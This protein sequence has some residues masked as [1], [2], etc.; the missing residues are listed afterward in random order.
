MI[1]RIF[2]QRLEA[3]RRKQKAVGLNIVFHLQLVLKI[4]IC[5]NAR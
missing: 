3:Q 4:S 5:S 1:N 2:H